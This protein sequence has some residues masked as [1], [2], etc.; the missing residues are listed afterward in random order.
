MDKKAKYYKAL[1]YSYDLY[2]RAWKM[3]GRVLVKEINNEFTGIMLV[4]IY[5]LNFKEYEKVYAYRCKLGQR[6]R[7]MI[8]KP[9]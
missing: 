8:R 9:R 2:E 6:Y 4:S 3:Y 1:N 7:N 5:D